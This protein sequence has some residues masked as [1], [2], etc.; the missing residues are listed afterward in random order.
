M[1]ASSKKKLR[2]EQNLA[3][4][5]EKQ[6]NEQKEAKK[7]KRYT[8]TFVIAMILVVLIAVGSVVRVPIIGAL[9]RGSHAVN[10]GTHELTT[11]EMGYFYVDAINEHYNEAYNTYGNYVVIRH[12]SGY[13]TLYGHLNTINTKRGRYV[14]TNTK[15]GTVGSTGMSTGPHLHFAV[16]KNG[17]G[18]NPQNLWN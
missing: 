11:T 7:L 9:D 6:L 8:W 2:K 10:I 3:A 4:M 5:T 15:I 1:S 17:K 13:Q 14:Y 12:H 16:Y 18:V